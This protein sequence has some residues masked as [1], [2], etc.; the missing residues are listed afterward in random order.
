MFGST[1]CQSQSKPREPERR[2]AKKGTSADSACH[3][4]RHDHMLCFVFEFSQAVDVDQFCIKPNL[5][6]KQNGSKP[7]KAKS[8]AL[9]SGCLRCLPQGDASVALCSAVL[10]SG[11]QTCVS[12]LWLRSFL[13]KALLSVMNELVGDF[14]PN[15]CF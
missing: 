3:A 15:E 10:S 5:S 13:F 6:Q 12:T 4:I 9:K 1:P 11:H 2:K 8:A 14:N 7:A